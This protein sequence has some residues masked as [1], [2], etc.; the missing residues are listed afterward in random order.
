MLLL[1][2]ASMLAAAVKIQPA[3]ADN[4]DWW[5]MFHHDL[6]HTGTS[7][8]TGPTTN[9]T[10]WTYT[11]GG[12][13]ISSPAVVGCLVY[14]DSYDDNVYC[15]NA[16]TGAFVW[17]YTTGSQIASSPTVAGG[18]VYVGSFDDNVYCLKATNGAF[19]WSYK[20]GGPVWSSPAVV[21]G[22]VYVGSYDGNVYCLNATSGAFVWS[23]KTGSYVL[24]SPAVVGGSV[25]VG[26]GDDNVYCLNAGTGALIWKYT[27]GSWVYS[28]P[29]VVGGLVYV[30]S[31]DDNVYCLNA[32]T[33][34]FV[35]NYTTGS[36][37]WSSPAVVGGLVY[38]GSYDKNVYCLN[39]ATGAQVWN[40]TTI[41]HLEYMTGWVVFSSPAVVGGLVYFG[42]WDNNT[43]CLNADTGALVWS[44]ETANEVWSSPA[45]VNGVVYVGSYDGKIYAFGSSSTSQTYYVSFTESGLSA[46]TEW[47][48]TF[49]S[50]TQSSTSSS[51][52][53]DNVPN[54]VYGFSI[55]P[56]TGYTAAPSQTSGR[57]TV[58]GADVPEP[59]TF[60]PVYTVTFTES[61]LSAG[62]EWSVTFNGI[63]SGGSSNDVT[64]YG[65]EDGTYS[66]TVDNVTGSVAPPADESVT[67]ASPS[68]G[69]VTVN[70]A[71]VNQAIAFQYTV[72]SWDPVM[73][74]YDVQEFAFANW[75]AASGGVCYGMSSTAVLYFTHYILGDTTCPY[76]PSQVLQANSTSD[77]NVGDAPTSPITG[78]PTLT[79]LNNASLAIV[80]NQVFGA[81]ASNKL[82]PSPSAT[83]P[84]EAEQYEDLIGNLTIGQPVVLILG[85]AT[86]WMHAVVAWGA[87]T[88]GN[89]KD[90][91]DVAIYLSDP[92]YN[93]TTTEAIINPV[94]DSFIY[95]GPNNW[96]SN[97]GFNK[98]YVVDPATISEFWAEEWANAS[99]L[100]PGYGGISLD[101]LWT[102]FITGYNIVL[103]NKMVT[104]DCNGLEDY[105]TASGDSQA[106]VDGIPGSS[107]I[108]QGTAQ[109]YALTQDYFSV[110]DPNSN[111][112]TILIAR[113]DNESGQLVGYGYLLNATTTQGLLNYTAT[114]S[115]SG[116]S[117]SAGDNALNA[118]VTCFSATLQGYSVSDVL[119]TQ[120]D[121]GQTVN[122]TAPCAAS[123]TAFKTVV[124]QGYPVPVNVTITNVGNNPEN[125]TLTLYA[126]ATALDSEMVLNLLNGTSVNLACVGNTSGCVYGNY[127]I[128]VYCEPSG[129][130]EAA[131]N[132]TYVGI[133]EVTIPGDIKGDGVV[134]ILD[135]IVL[136]NHFLETPSSPGWSTGGANADINGDGV[137]NILDAIIL[138]NHFLQHYP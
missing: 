137:V 51:I 36:Y 2:V 106:F 76:F 22:L 72:S 74:S 13:V 9:N 97:I 98:F 127:T 54:G 10:L 66:F 92:N 73:D 39:A 94:T 129:V 134:N 59:I 17:S 21:G 107:G 56:P 64:F 130:N 43:Y 78:Y 67:V 110:G 103:A 105:F 122:L 69:T 62:T 111:Q 41:G 117:I 53:F 81:P 37:V 95:D 96:Y 100:F 33:G 68:S 120:I 86:L 14:V 133:I 91:G 102:F 16:A 138:G 28:S 40:F 55:T 12:W 4:V 84:N 83:F 99:T 26:S 49:N 121:A 112:S 75:Q 108:E 109:I 34:A 24:S 47:S 44:Y 58:N 61:G 57:I 88:I 42:S 46:G 7:T 118:S 77:L 128:S 71:N 27:T 82:I 113:V 89:G 8:S 32:A 119:T 115:D 19:V 29:D 38:F 87:G 5:P 18:L 35:W 85:N 131:N 11:T 1:L 15:L 104:I 114:P 25:Y 90:A 30:G 132:F 52:T 20:T 3:S 63:T 101:N 125:V 31:G 79:T 80:F 50:Q 126:N 70:D 65:V 23:Y 48:V 135:A 123:F 116:L 124:G 93:E 6:N 45:V 60:F 136:G